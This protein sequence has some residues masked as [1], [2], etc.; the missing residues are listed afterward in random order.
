VRLLELASS[1]QLPVFYPI[2]MPVPLMMVKKK[3]FVRVLT[4]FELE[5][6]VHVAHA[7]KGSYLQA[8]E[9]FLKRE[10][11]KYLNQ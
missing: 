2:C 9:L 11:N 10:R 5:I 8:A 1:V 6:I 3:I 4:R 7:T